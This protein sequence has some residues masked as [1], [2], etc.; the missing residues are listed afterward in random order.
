[1]YQAW[2]RVGVKYIPWPQ[3]F[4]RTTQQN[5]SARP[6]HTYVAG[7]ALTGASLNKPS[8]AQ[9]QVM[10]WASILQSRSRRLKPRRAHHA[11]VIPASNRCFLMLDSMLD[12]PLSLISKLPPPII[13][14]N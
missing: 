14:W 9:A 2:E 5:F 7:L 12:I 1:M 11:T 10:A 8:R 4:P 3:L 13:A 6:R